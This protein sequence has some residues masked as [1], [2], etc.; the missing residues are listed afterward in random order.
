MVQMDARQQ[1]EVQS[2]L[3]TVSSRT[4]LIISQLRRYQALA[5]VYAAQSQL[6]A[7]MGVDPGLTK[8]DSMS[9]P[10]LTTAVGQSF[11][12]WR[13]GLTAAAVATRVLG[14][15]DPPQS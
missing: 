9:L 12:Q 1:A 8:A 5:Q 2:K 6:E 11:E 3:E 10:Q 15:G 7:T 14:P 13:R 4:S